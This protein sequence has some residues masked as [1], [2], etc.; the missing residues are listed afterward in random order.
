MVLRGYEL[1]DTLC[2]FIIS[3]TAADAQFLFGSS[4]NGMNVR[5]VDRAKWRYSVTVTS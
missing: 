2:A 4:T 3:Q 1:P 5:S